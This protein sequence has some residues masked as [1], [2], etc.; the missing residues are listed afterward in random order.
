[1]EY[2]RE[3]KPDPKFKVIFGDSPMAIDGADEYYYDDL[4]ISYNYLNIIIP[5]LKVI[6]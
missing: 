6:I 2:Y 1:M 3:F 4:D 5:V